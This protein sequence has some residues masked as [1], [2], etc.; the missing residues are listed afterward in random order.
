MHRM[1]FALT[2]LSLGVASAALA[3]TEPTTQPTE[4]APATQPA[5]TQPSLKA[6]SVSSGRFQ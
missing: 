5:E 4:V 2:F 6:A 1:K 3:Q